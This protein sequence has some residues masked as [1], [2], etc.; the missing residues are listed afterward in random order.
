M[1]FLHSCWE[2]RDNPSV[3]YAMVAK[4]DL[5]MASFIAFNNACLRCLIG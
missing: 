4:E 2:P 3:A 5:D 1:G